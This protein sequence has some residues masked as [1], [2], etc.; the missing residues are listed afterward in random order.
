VAATARQLRRNG[1]SASDHAEETCQFQQEA[2]KHKKAYRIRG[3]TSEEGRVGVRFT[4]NTG[5]VLQTD[6]PRLAGGADRA[7][8]P[9]ELLLA[10]LAGCT[11][12]T[13]VF[14]G[15]NLRPRRLVIERIEFDLEAWRDERG[16]LS[17]PVDAPPGFP[18]RLRSVTGTVLV[19]AARNEPI[20]DSI[21]ELLKEQTEI[22]C[23]VAN[24]MLA[25]GCDMNVRWVDGTKEDVT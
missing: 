24:M 11:Q 14:V 1:S 17:L 6:L 25:S 13:A 18:S 23:P 4:T 7:A 10:A 19:Y 9:V 2:S 20:D 3:R 5:H 8:Q 16:A 12:A 22:R 21:L 15:R